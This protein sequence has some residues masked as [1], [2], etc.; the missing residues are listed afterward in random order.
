[1]GRGIFFSFMTQ[2]T[3]LKS[4]SFLYTVKLDVISVLFKLR[5]WSSS[6]PSLSNRIMFMDLFT[7]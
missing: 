1:M 6:T 3:G 5:P 7:Q 4:K 2:E